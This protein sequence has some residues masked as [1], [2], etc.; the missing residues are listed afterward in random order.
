MNAWLPLVAW[1]LFA[2]SMA[3]TASL[4]LATSG[5]KNSGADAD[6][7]EAA[8]PPS[9]S[10]TSASP[11]SA[12]PTG[13][14]R[15]AASKALR[16]LL[17]L[18]SVLLRGLG[19]IAV[20]ISLLCCAGGWALLAAGTVTYNLH[21]ELDNHKPPELSNGPNFSQD[22]VRATLRAVGYLFIAIIGFIPLA[23]YAVRL[24]TYLRPDSRW[25]QLLLCR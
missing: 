11:T 13:G 21:S 3:A 10:P 19:V 4:A 18:P 22:G 17:Q 24:R 2:A 16:V 25:V 15:P 9:P 23:C 12:S 8:H 1:Y 6:D 7:L 14:L 5:L 20:I